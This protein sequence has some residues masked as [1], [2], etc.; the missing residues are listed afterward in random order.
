MLARCNW[1]VNPNV[2]WKHVPYSQHVSILSSDDHIGRRDVFYLHGPASNFNFANFRISAV[3]WN[4]FIER[5]GPLDG[6]P[7]QLSDRVLSSAWPSAVDFNF[8]FAPDSIPE[9]PGFFI[10]AAIIR[11]YPFIRSF[12]LVLLL[13]D[14][15]RRIGKEI[16][17]FNAIR[18][19]NG[20]LV[21]LPDN[22]VILL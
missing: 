2:T 8:S 22:W 6:S 18:F 1:T 21:F 14:S 19:S 9:S 11:P 16:T 13:V 20:P 17:G 3:D 12:I 5:N 4:R 15:T 10:T 7:N